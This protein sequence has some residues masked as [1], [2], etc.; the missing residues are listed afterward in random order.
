MIVNKSMYPLQTGFSVISKMQE[1][2]ADLQVQLGTGQKSSTLAGMGRDLPMSLSVR[3]RLS[4]IEGYSANIDTVSLRMTFLDN[5]MSRLDKI[6]GEARTSAVQGQYGTNNINMAT[7]P[8][9]SK[10][11]LDEVVTLLNGDVAGRYLFGGANTD[12]A[13]LPD[14]QSLLEGIGGKDG[15]KTILGERKAADAGVLGNGRMVTAQPATNSVSLTEDGTHPFGFKLLRVTSTAPGTALDVGSVGP[16]AA[17]VP[18]AIQTGDTNT[19]I[20]AAAPAE[21]IKPGQ[22]ITFGLQLPDGLDTQIT[23]TAIAPEDG[24]AATGQFIV[25]SDPDANAASFKVA[26]DEKLQL[27]ADTD[28]AAASNFAAAKMFFNGPGEPALRVDGNDPANAQGLRLATEADTVQ[29][30]A[31]QTSAVSADGMGRLS[32]STSGATITLAEASPSSTSYGFQISGATVAP[33]AAGT[34]ILTANTTADPSSSSVTFDSNPVLG[35]TVSLTLTE[36][37]GTTRQVQLTAVN[38]KAGA[39][40]FSLGATP[41]ETAGNF[42]AALSSAVTSAA[43][44]AEGNPRQSVTAQVDDSTKVNYGIQA[45]ESGLLRMVRTIAAMSVETYP[46]DSAESRG[47]FDAMAVRQQAQMSEAHNSER[48][49]LEIMTMELGVAHGTLNNS[50]ARHTDYKAQLDN[51]LSD[52]ETVSKEDVAMEI[53][54][55]QTRLQA[56]Y[57]V[58]SMVSQLSLVNFL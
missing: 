51:L 20:F 42:A 33:P 4:A 57:Q 15:F 6:E 5:A 25:T 16:S 26:L 55:L 2:F 23:L 34:R 8:G 50:K 22:T 48:G 32:V 36:P 10:A 9:L 29:W 1:R 58:T 13:P 53:L 49:S 40:Q 17:V 35:D 39:G 54:A 47:L 7:L 45:N 3:S 44:A 56:S 14:T 19:I 31:G 43:A 52:V 18:P 41:A 12:T 30:Y 37:N 38:G 21:Q 27:A 28:L 24:P 46:D 11:R